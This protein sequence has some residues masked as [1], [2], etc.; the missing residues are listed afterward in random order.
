MPTELSA[1]PNAA[2]GKQRNGLRGFAVV[3]ARSCAVR[4]ALFAL[5]ADPT[6]GRPLL[7]VSPFV[8]ASSTGRDLT[9][10]DTRPCG[11][12]SAFTIMGSHKS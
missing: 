11:V 8:H 12:S 10:N 4:G 5:R 9:Q 3:R 6:C 1:G 7:R 2:S